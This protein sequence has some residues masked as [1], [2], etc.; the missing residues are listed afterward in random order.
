VFW[1][2]ETRFQNM[3]Q[4]SHWQNKELK[5]TGVMKSYQK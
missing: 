4:I 2:Q 1:S 3:L 5:L